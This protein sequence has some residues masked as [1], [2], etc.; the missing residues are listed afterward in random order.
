M[1]IQRKLRPV[2]RLYVRCLCASVPWLLVAPISQKSQSLL[3]HA[4]TRLSHVS[5][6]RT[7]AH[8]SRS[9]RDLTYLLGYHPWFSHLFSLQAVAQTAEAKEAHYRALFIPDGS[10]DSNKETHLEAF[11]R[12]LPDLPYPFPLEELL[13]ALRRNLEEFLSEHYAD[14]VGRPKPMLGEVG[15]DRSFRVPFLAY[16][17]SEPPA[18][19]DGP[20]LTPFFVPVAHQEAILEA[21]L[22]LA[23][24]LGVNVS[25]HSVK[26]PA[27]TQ[28]VFARML[29]RHG[30]K[31]DAISVDMHSC[32]VSVATWKDIEASL[33]LCFTFNI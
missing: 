14:P 15:L 24:E 13:A 22:A 33:L 6:N 11:R 17:E 31:F 27:Q 10:K 12:V 32:G 25:L 18:S 3:A 23:I 29:A 21:Q 9:A 1:P 16:G 30:A 26:A 7:S 28:A 4:Q 8:N 19:E 2:K 20:R 5:V